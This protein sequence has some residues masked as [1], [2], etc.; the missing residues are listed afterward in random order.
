MQYRYYSPQLIA[1]KS[2]ENTS[3]KALMEKRMDDK[4][5]L[6][7]KYKTAQN[8]DMVLVSESVP[9]NTKPLPI[10]NQKFRTKWLCTIERGKKI[11]GIPTASV[12][13]GEAVNLSSH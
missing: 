9:G 10:C 5:T 6:D 8:V 2:K 7:Q 4:T 13:N 3:S 1:G 12:D 11:S